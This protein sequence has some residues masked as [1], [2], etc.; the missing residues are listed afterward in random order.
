MIINKLKS[1]GL[2]SIN[3]LNDIEKIELKR[4]TKELLK[5]AFFVGVIP[6]LVALL[7]DMSIGI[8]NLNGLNEITKTLIPTDIIYMNILVLYTTGHM[9]FLYVLGICDHL[10]VGISPIFLKTC[11]FFSPI[12]EVLLQVLAVI[13]G[14]FFTLVLLLASEN[15]S[16]SFIYLCIASFLF[17]LSVSALTMN[18]VIT[19]NHKKKAVNTKSKA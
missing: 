19:I 7:I 17:F 14:L 3:F 15:F 11:E 13:S 10:D 9:L 1:K 18:R 2:F 12:A 4:A 5:I 6:S 16:H 8:Q